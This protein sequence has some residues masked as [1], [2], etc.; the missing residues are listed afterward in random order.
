MY[1]EDPVQQLSE[2]VAVAAATPPADIMDIPSDPEPEP[3]KPA[4]L[5]TPVP[6]AAP[7]TPARAPEAPTTMETTPPTTPTFPKE[8]PVEIKPPE[9]RLF[10]DMKLDRTEEKKMARKKA[11]EDQQAQARAISLE[12]EDRQKNL[13]ADAREGAVITLSLIHI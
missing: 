11:R 8:K 7:P 12:R 9:P 1:I 13:P 6:V 2:H 4:R 5:E 10:D 3:V